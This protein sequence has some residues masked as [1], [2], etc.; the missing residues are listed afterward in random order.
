MVLSELFEVVPTKIKIL[1]GISV[2]V[3]VGEILINVM[4]F[5]WNLIVVNAVNLASG[6]TTSAEACMPTATGIY[7]FGINFAD[8]W[9]LMLIIFMPVLAYFAWAW[10]AQTLKGSG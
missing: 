7:I 3:L 6:C 8:F 5:L 4:L 2:F 1:L 10:Y 9:T